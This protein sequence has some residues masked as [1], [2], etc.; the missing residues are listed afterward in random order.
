MQG[1]TVKWC[2]REI[3]AKL[4]EHPGRPCEEVGIR[5]EPSGTDRGKWVKEGNPGSRNKETNIESMSSCKG[6]QRTVQEGETARLSTFLP[7]S[8]AAR[9]LQ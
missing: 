1:E 3:Q 9:R 5:A 4:I 6:G 8:R 7:S 2:C